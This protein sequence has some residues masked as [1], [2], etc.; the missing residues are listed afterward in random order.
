MSSTA[1]P[2]RQPIAW[3]LNLDAE[4]ELAVPG[5]FTPSVRLSALVRRQGE[6]LIGGLVAP[7]DTVVEPDAAGATSLQG[8]LGM[9]WSPTPRALRTLA[10]TG[11][12][13]LATPPMSVLRRANARPFAAGVRAELC[14]AS[15]AKRIASRMEEV[16]PL[17]AEPARLGWLVRRSFGAAGRGRRRLTAGKQPPEDL[18]WLAAGLARGPLVVEPWVEITCEY[19]RSGWV[20]PAGRI[21]L[22]NP[23]WQETTPSGAWVRT[24][25]AQGHR[26]AVAGDDEAL[27]EA[28]ERAGRALAAAG[29]F[30]PFG[31][32]AFRH[33]GA[34][35]TR[36]VLNPLSEVNARFT[37]DWAHAMARSPG[38][39][40]ERLRELLA[41]H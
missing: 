38:Q 27:L 11:A 21:V 33:R 26:G 6:R 31:I 20:S 8:H 13:T 4:E 10:R 35:G 37:M 25:L 30:G 1:K 34:E 14:H 15:F 40:A 2:E 18:A 7:G 3:V 23:C 39:G 12:A 16:L 36:D 29:Y 5:A 32:D 9:A 19:T 22:S 41:M 28:L 24:T 17:L